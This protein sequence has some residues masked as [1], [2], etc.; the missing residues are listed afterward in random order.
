V[1]G[2]AAPSPGDFTICFRC[3]HVMTFGDDLKLRALTGAEIEELAGDPRL[4]K[5]Q[6][7]R[8]EVMKLRE[9]VERS[10]RK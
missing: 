10:G 1:L 3:G 8:G 2:D 5:M 6:T 9:I 4:V 7:A